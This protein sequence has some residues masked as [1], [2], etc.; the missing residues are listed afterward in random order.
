MYWKF[1]E[2]HSNYEY[3]SNS[4]KIFVIIGHSEKRNNLLYTLYKSSG[5]VLYNTLTFQG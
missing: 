5:Y 2:Y 3:Y 1:Y 4:L